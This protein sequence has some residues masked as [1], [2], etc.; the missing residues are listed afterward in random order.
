MP[1][2][3][4]ARTIAHLLLTLTA[5]ACTTSAAQPPDRDCDTAGAPR[6][7]ATGPAVRP[8]TL[9]ARALQ[10]PADQL[11][12]SVLASSQA[13]ETVRSLCDEVGPR[14]AGSAG[15]K[16]AVAWGLRTLEARG[17]TRVHAEKVIVPHWERGAGEAHL[18]SPYPHALAIAALG[19]S[20]GTPPDG[21][22]AEVIGAES[23]EALQ[24]LGQGRVEGKIAFLFPRTERARDGRGYGRTTG[25][26]WRAASA[27]AKLGAVGVVIRSIGTDNERFPHT[28]GMRYAL[29]V[30]QIPAAALS[31][32]D[33]EMLERLIQA[34]APVRLSMTLGCRTL[35]D[36]ESANVIGDVPGSAAPE[37]IVLLG[38]HLDAWDLGFGAVD[39]GAGVGIVVDAARAIAALPRRPRRTV[40]VALFAN[41]ENGLAGAKAYAE[42]HKE[43]LAKHVVALEADAGAGRVYEARFLGGE[44]ARP[45]FLELLAPLEPFGIAASDKDAHGGA[46]LSPLRPVGVPFIDLFQD[47]S[48]YFDV[49]HTANDTMDKVPK[50]DLD[51]AAAAFAAMAFAV[52]DMPGNLGRIPEAKRTEKR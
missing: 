35:P 15:D 43:E 36:A 21:L 30:P 34:G 51:Q 19:G 18:V 25:V 26:R 46:D 1:N 37:E 22:E 12:E 29:G 20:V 49:H 48:L 38:A 44:T 16:A 9:P 47:M 31:I 7:A 52:A 2:T 28:G 39:D 17:L 5:C 50:E 40:R 23:I 42:T 14:L 41:E 11:R 32:P 3:A 6:P 33:A 27:A 45:A 13:W 4:A 24:K 8:G 10:G